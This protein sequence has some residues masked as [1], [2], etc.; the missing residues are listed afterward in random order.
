MFVLLRADLCYLLLLC[1]LGVMC[2][3]VPCLL[4]LAVLCLVCSRAVGVLCVLCWFARVL[5]L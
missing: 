3:G 5:C 2:C 1:A 4:V